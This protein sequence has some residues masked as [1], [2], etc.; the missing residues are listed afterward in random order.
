MS[1]DCRQKLNPAP[2]PSPGRAPGCPP[3]GRARPAAGTA[4]PAARAVLAALALA[5]ALGSVA[6][7]AKYN[8]YFNAKRAFEN[9][10]RVREDALRRNQDPP[11]PQGTQKS[12]YETAIA[13]AQ[14]VLDDYPGHSL[15]D[16]ALFLRAKAYY[17]LESYRMSIRQ[18]DLLF[19]NFPATEY[20]EEALY[21]Q[22]LNHLL[23]GALD[24]SQDYL[25]QLE[26]AFPDSRYQAEVSRVSGDNSY[27]LEDWEGAR[28]AYS[29]YLALGEE[30]RERDRVALKLG[31]C[32]WE[33]ER[34]AEADTVLADMLERVGPGELEFRAQLLRARVMARAGDLEGADDLLA[35]LDQAAAFHKSEGE[36]TLARSEVFVWRKRP[37]EAATLLQS[38]P[39]E[40]LTPVVKARA[41]DLLAYRHLERQE[42][43]E[44]FEQFKVAM[45]QRDKLD[46]PERTRRLNDQL[47]DYLAADKDLA[48]AKGDRVPRLKLL[49]ANALLFGF[50]RPAR[51]AELY[52]EAAADSA[53]DSLVAARALYGLWLAQET[54]LGAPDS[55]AAVAGELLRRYPGSAQAREVAASDSGTL[56]EFLLAERSRAQERN[57][58]GLTDEERRKLEEVSIASSGGA[59][60]GPAGGGP[61]AR[62]RMVYLARREPLVFPPPAVIVPVGGRAATAGTATAAEPLPG[63]GGAGPLPG[64]G[65]VSSQPVSGPGP[66]DEAAGAATPPP[67]GGDPA[68]P[69]A[70]RPAEPA[71]PGTQPD[72]AP[73]EAPE[74]KPEKPVKERDPEWDRLRAPS[75]AGRP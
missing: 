21:L 30:A 32:L 14:K 75:A 46:D 71:S 25:G 11:K 63:A 60:S 23:I 6:G 1:R 66:V 59:G 56:L 19:Q 40:W 39:N 53:A 51:A 38:M 43:A 34:F 64:S 49:Q 54:R 65:A 15:S 12:D 61:Q 10:E 58:A 3:A 33:L 47:K 2:R 73:A 17:R 68:A 70:T 45:G 48:A 41:A 13:K 22:A 37:D 18:F 35:S 36:L 27:A 28:A 8:T 5:L 4:S 42:Y 9:A 16:D 72:G 26:R 52:R 67:A 20:L 55:A 7:C 74:A 57:L 44:A 69:G 31:E 62:R 50:D 29:Q 24:R